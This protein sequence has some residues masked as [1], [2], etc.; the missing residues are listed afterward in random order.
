MCILGVWLGNISDGR[1][2]DGGGTYVSDRGDD[3]Y[4]P[5]DN[6]PCCH[7]RRKAGTDCVTCDVELLH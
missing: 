6:Y 2:T 7:A 5:I 4:S 3:D 1:D